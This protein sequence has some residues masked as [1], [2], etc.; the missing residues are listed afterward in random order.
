MP[1]Y[2]PPTSKRRKKLLVF[3]GRTF[4]DYD[5]LKRKLDRLTEN[6]LDVMLVTGGG[7]DKVAA[8]A[9]RWAARAGYKHVVRFH[10]DPE[11]HKDKAEAVRYKEA[12][13]FV[14]ETGY[15][16]VFDDGVDRTLKAGIAACRL[17]GVKLK[18][19]EV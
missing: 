1:T 11:R 19:V 15:A 17:Y 12:A 18:V 7:K 13:Q 9:E 4:S 10:P 16:V 2:S 6:F 14:G 5:L 8:M 3:G